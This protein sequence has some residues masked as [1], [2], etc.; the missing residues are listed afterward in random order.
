MT[1]RW[2]ILQMMSS[3]QDSSREAVPCK[4]EPKSKGKGVSAP[5]SPRTPSPA[6]SLL[7]ISSGTMTEKSCK[8]GGDEASFSGAYLP[9][10]SD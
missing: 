4:T 8:G 7:T 6:A 5:S 10:E 9:F 3:S 2:D 1:G